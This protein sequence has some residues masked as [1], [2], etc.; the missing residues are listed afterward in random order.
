MSEH[1]LTPPQPGVMVRFVGLTNP[2]NV[3]LPADQVGLVVGYD[4]KWGTAQVL[5]SNS[6]MGWYNKWELAEVIE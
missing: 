2:A 4:E 5:W 6:K 3:N 1:C